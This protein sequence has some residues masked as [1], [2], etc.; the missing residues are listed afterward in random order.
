MFDIIHIREYVIKLPGLT[1]QDITR[2]FIQFEKSQWFYYQ[3]IFTFCVA[4][5]LLT[6]TR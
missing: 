6:L 1:N 2:A 3:L 5:E 4:K